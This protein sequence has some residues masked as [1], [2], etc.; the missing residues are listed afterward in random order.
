MGRIRY[1]KFM[2]LPGTVAVSARIF[3]SRI[4]QDLCLHLDMKLLG[5]QF[6]HAMHPV[7][8]TRTNL[9]IVGEVIF[10]TFAWQI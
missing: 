6:T 4:L 9:L 3:G 5:N 2:T 1:T 8:A 10:D 7:T